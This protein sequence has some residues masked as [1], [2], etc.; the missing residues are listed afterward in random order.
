MEAWK[1]RLVTFSVS[2]WNKYKLF[3][4]AMVQALLLLKWEAANATDCSE[5]PFSLLNY[6]IE[7]M[8]YPSHWQR[9]FVEWNSFLCENNPTTPYI[10]RVTF[11]HPFSS[12]LLPIPTHLQFFHLT[13]FFQCFLNQP[14]QTVSVQCSV[15]IMACATFA[16]R[17]RTQP[18][19]T[20]KQT[21][22]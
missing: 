3:Y 15:C 16:P 5:F 18:E 13:S 1:T 21:L 20:I 2:L 22:V 11:H 10:S 14:H 6:V 8:W 9:F 4:W 17:N 7:F 19:C 12:I